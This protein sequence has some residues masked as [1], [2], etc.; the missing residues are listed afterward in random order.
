MVYMNEGGLALPKLAKE[1][2]HNSLTVIRGDF[3]LLPNLTIMQLKKSVGD[4]RFL[5]NR[6]AASTQQAAR[7]LIQIGYRG[8]SSPLVLPN[9]LQKYWSG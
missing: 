8:T 4:V 7:C 9:V 1:G 5:S 3:F 6:E 2:C